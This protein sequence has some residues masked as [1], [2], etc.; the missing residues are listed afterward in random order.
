MLG[1]EKVVKAVGIP[2][3]YCDVY[4]GTVR[5]VHVR[6][7]LQLIAII[8]ANWWLNTSHDVKCYAG[9]LCHA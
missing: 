1:K 4:G 8:F 6:P 7:Q 2:G 3:T 5:K 9:Q